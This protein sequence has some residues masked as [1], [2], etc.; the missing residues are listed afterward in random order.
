MSEQDDLELAKKYLVSAGLH[1]QNLAQD[2]LKRILYDL[3]T[4]MKHLIHKL[5]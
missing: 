5:G 3:A 1:I 4:A 2:D